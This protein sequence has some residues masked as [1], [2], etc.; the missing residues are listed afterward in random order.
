MARDLST[1]QATSRS[2]P[3][4]PRAAAPLATKHF[5]WQDPLALSEVLKDDEVVTAAERPNSPAKYALVH[6]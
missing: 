2:L 6:N 5:D 3:D 4:L 1:A